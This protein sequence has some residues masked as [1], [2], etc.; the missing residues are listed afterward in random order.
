LPIADIVVDYERWWNSE[1]GVEMAGGVAEGDD[2]GFTNY[3][4]A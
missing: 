3:R 1:G 2:G 4:L